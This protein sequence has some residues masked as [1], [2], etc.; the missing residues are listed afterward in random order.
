MN[1]YEYMILTLSI[2]TTG[3]VWLTA[4][5][6]DF[7]GPHEMPGGWWSLMNERF[8]TQNKREDPYATPLPPP[9]PPSWPHSS[10]FE[11]YSICVFSKY[12]VLHQAS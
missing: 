7:G 2:A 12:L 10:F 5:F 8:E 4:K 6:Y 9:L 3:I 11:M 1:T